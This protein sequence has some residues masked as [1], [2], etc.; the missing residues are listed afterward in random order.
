MK[1]KLQFVFI[2]TLATCQ[3]VSGNSSQHQNQPKAIF[4]VCSCSLGKLMEVRDF[5]ENDL[6]EY[7]NLLAV[8][9]EKD[10]K[11]QVTFYGDD[12]VETDDIAIEGMSR[13]QIREVLKGRSIL[14]FFELEEI[15]SNDEL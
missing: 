5:L 3:A 2:L 15:I 6:P 9:Y 4:K 12:G 13:F 8:K 11:A 1:Y 7:G 14:P 10:S